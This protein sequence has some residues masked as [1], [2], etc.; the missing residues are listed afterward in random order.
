MYKALTQSFNLSAFKIM[1]L[2]VPS[3]LPLLLA[4]HRPCYYLPSPIPLLCF[5]ASCLS[6]SFTLL[7]SQLQ[8][9]SRASLWANLPPN[10]GLTLL[11]IFS[12]KTMHLGLG[13]PC[14]EWKTSWLCSKEEFVPLVVTVPASLCKL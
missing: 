12:D 8:A 11:L 7:S 5:A 2:S 6:R 9:Q 1:Y 14:Y 3:C 4:S 13:V 10:G